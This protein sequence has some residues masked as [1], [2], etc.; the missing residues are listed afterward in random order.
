M[1]KNW[2]KSLFSFFGNFTKLYGLSY[3]GSNNTCPIQFYFGAL[4]KNKSIKRHFSGM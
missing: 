4:S 2:H 1:R 3:Y